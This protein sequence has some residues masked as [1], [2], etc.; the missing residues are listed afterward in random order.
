[1]R[2]KVLCFALTCILM[3]IGVPASAQHEFVDLGLS[4][5]WATCNVGADRPE[6]AGDLY[7]WGETE[8]KT[9]YSFATYKFCVDGKQGNYTKYCDKDNK[10]VLDQ[11]DDVAHVKWGG[12]WRM[13]TGAELDELREECVWTW[14]KENGVNGYRVS[15]KKEGFENNSIFLPVNVHNSSNAIEHGMPAEFGLYWSSSLSYNANSFFMGRWDHANGYS[16]FQ[17]TPTGNASFRNEGQSVRPV[18]P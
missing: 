6:D 18:H 8:T 4:V 16:F 14:T 2:K 13:P 9:N 12:S 11:E 5:K 10:T 3:S 1:M 15:G 7:S 17:D